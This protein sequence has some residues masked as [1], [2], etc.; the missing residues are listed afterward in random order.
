VEIGN[1]PSRVRIY[2]IKRKDG[3]KKPK[4][5]TRPDGSWARYEYDTEG[6]RTKTVEPFLDAAPA[7]AENLCKV[8]TVIYLDSKPQE[9]RGV[10]ILG[11]EVERGYKVNSD[12]IDHIT[13]DIGGRS[14]FR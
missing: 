11:Q 5:E 7:S 1:G 9:T 10:T 4:E 13:K 3:Y 6:R 12:Y 14:L 8:T 2:T